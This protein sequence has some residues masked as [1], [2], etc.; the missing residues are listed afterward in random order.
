MLPY[1]NKW[2]HTFDKN[3]EI[4]PILEYFADKGCLGFL[5]DIGV[6][7]ALDV[8]T[9][10]FGHKN[11]RIYLNRES[12][13]VYVV[14]DSINRREKTYFKHKALSVVSNIVIYRMID[15]VCQKLSIEFGDEISDDLKGVWNV[16]LSSLHDGF[17]HQ[18]QKDF[19]YSNYNEEVRCVELTLFKEKVCIYI[20]DNNAVLVETSEHE[21]FTGTAGEF[22]FTKQLNETLTHFSN[23]D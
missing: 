16:F 21:S 1:I 3:D 2:N 8:F 4:K 11:E 19:S 20:Y 5:L 17:I 10:T 18:L 14:I 23:L 9:F 13:N 12:E 15:E 22:A 7:K 6:S